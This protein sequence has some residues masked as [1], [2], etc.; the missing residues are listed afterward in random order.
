MMDYSRWSPEGERSFAV[1]VVLYGCHEVRGFRSGS[2]WRL[3]RG[4]DDVD[5]GGW[6][7]VRSDMD[8]KTFIT[9]T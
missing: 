6:P 7:Q 4:E 1:V 5:S 3:T 8:S 2:R 9:T